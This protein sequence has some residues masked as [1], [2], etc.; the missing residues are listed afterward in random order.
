M[1]AILPRSA[2]WRRRT[3]KAIAVECLLSDPANQGLSDRQVARKCCVSHQLV[4]RVRGAEGTAANAIRLARRGDATYA[5]KVHA[6]NG[7]R[8]AARKKAALESQEPAAIERR[9]GLARDAYA[10]MR[11]RA[12]SALTPAGQ[13]CLQRD[14]R[15]TNELER[16]D[17]EVRAAGQAF[18]QGVP[19]AEARF[20]EAIAACQLGWARTVD[21]LRRAQGQR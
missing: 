12:L 3:D 9:R 4:A 7:A 18:V 13:R 10:T 2:Q 15:R 8:A 6:I 11:T 16:L 5:M 19:G 20:H 14:W 1:P 21:M 17:A